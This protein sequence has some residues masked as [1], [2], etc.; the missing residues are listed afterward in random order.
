MHFPISQLN[1]KLKSK[2][3]LKGLISIWGDI[4]VGKTTFALQTTIINALDGKNTVYI[5][6]KPNFPYEKIKNYIQTT[7]KHILDK[8]LFIQISD[9]NE[10]YILIFNLE[11]NIL[12]HSKEK[13]NNIDLIL[14]DSITNL[15]RLELN[16]EKKEKNFILNYKLNQILGN[17][18]YLNKK[19]ETE[20]LI[21]SEISRV[22][23]NGHTIQIQ[24]GGKIMDYWIAYSL[25]IER[26]EKLNYRKFILTKKEEEYSSQEYYLILTEKG[27][28]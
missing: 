18:Y 7:P 24:S 11:F 20:I 9:F 19:Y 17:L 1:K 15:Y 27:F 25:K 14:I 10:L 22:N 6:S 21:I 4:G 26:T 23:V 28:K 2:E 16:R 8:I 3:P 13:E 5:Y 12:D